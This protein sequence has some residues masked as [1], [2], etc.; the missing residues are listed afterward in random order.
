MT[1]I[2]IRENHVLI[3]GYVNVTGRFS[4]VLS[5]PI[6]GE[7]IEQIVPKT[8][9]RFLK[10]GYNVD[11]LFNHEKDR[12][13][14]SFNDGNLEL[15]EDNIGLRV[16]CTI[17]DKEVIEKAKRGQ[18][19]GWSFTFKKINDRWENE[20]RIKR[21]FVDELHLIEVSVLDIEPAY[22]GNSIEV[23]AS[24]FH[25]LAIYEKEL[26]ILKLKGGILK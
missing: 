25:D 20:G 3:V 8:F 6:Q 21:R 7:F 14:G 24:P 10:H 19:K 23:R 1:R 16:K 15:Y 12:K 9:E 17:T 5:H 11:L 22:F 13:L 26:E 18:L 4:R 2:E